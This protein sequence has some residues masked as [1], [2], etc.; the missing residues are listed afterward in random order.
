MKT[1]G[2]EIRS[3]PTFEQQLLHDNFV[4]LNL[5]YCTEDLQA[6]QGAI[7]LPQA[8]HIQASSLSEQIL[9]LSR[10][11]GSKMLVIE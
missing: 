2:T 9:S 3:S 6:L 1:C 8:L 11:F 10:N 5:S 4:K 7:R